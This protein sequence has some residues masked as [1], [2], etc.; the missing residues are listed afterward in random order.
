MSSKTRRLLTL[1]E[2]MQIVEV[3]N[4]DKLTVRALA[5]RFQIGKTQ[6]GEIIKKKE[7]LTAKWH[8]GG[9]ENQIRSF[10]K[11]EG[12]NIDKTCY[13][14]FRKAR[15]KSIPV[16]G[17]LIKAKA[18]EIAEHLGYKDFRA[19]DGWLEKFRKRHNISFKA[20]SGEA[21]SV[22]PNDVS[23]FLEK[24]PSLIK[25]YNLNDIYNADE[26]G[27][28][29]R[30]LPNK[31]LAFRSEK[32]TGGK[33]SKDRVTILHCVSMSGEKERLLVIGKAARPRAFKKLTVDSFPVTWKAN[34]KAWMTGDIMT[35]WLTEFDRKMMLEMRK[36]LLFLDNACS[37][38]QNIKLNNIKIIFLP[39]NTTSVCQPLDQGII[40]NFK[41]FYRS[42]IVKDILL[43]MDSI[44]STAELSKSIDLLE[45]IY[46]IKKAWQ[47][48]SSATIKNCFVKAGF[49]HTT[50]QV[51]YEFDAED[52]VPLSVL[53][54]L[55]RGLQETGMC[56]SDPDDFINMD[57]NLTV[58]DDDVTMILSSNND[59]IVVEENSD[60][61]IEV[62]DNTNERDGIN[63]FQ[64]AFNAITSV[65]SFMKKNE[66][67][68]G[69]EL[70]K[71]VE[72]YL[73]NAVISSRVNKMRQSSMLDYFNFK[74]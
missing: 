37:H 28:Y 32:C 49:K 41:T 12:L 74:N 57:E 45:A 18:K 22:N 15:N 21:A 23:E 36:I 64:E 50:D 72:V 71:N 42:L 67:F 60:D 43:K 33:L 7:E 48:V 39:P 27:L 69:F 24:L 61:E 1:K 63:T 13:E 51:H 16:S 52:D 47:Q 20:V 17:P 14:W 6:A 8:A 9:N 55:Y 4:S 35:E 66:D 26:T 30:A 5:K 11:S 54:E 53:A 2:K 31:T 10:L 68:K 56:N 29:Y 38:P 65:K 70:V 19:S 73:E 59:E 44:Q 58:E 34:K 62:Y 3:F 25:G 40:R 46:F